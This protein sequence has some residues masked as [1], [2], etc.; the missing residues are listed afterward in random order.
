MK[1]CSFLV[2]IYISPCAS[3]ARKFELSFDIYRSFVHFYMLHNPNYHIFLKKF[4]RIDK[5]L[6]Y[7]SERA[8]IY[9]RGYYLM[10][11]FQTLV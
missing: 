1:N 9:A 10:N 5:N 2:D 7:Y 11:I 4:P 3:V 6:N 8:Q